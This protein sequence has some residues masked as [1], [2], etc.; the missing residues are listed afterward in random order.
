M[1]NLDNF[2]SYLSDTEL[3]IF[4]TYHFDDFLVTSQKRIIREVQR[5]QLSIDKLSEL[6]K[7]GLIAYSNNNYP[8]LKF[9]T[10][11]CALS[12]MHTN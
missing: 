4:I 5:R 10:I 11:A 6:F 3:A 12:E 1:K 8:C 9:D 2:L 7:K